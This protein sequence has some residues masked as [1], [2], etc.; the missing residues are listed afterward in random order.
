M[1]LTRLLSLILVLLMFTAT[2]TACVEQGEGNGTTGTEAATVV[3]TGDSVGDGLDDVKYNGATV[4][5]LYWNDATNA[6]F[7]VSE[8][9]ADTINDSVYYRNANVEAHLGIKIAWN[10][11][12]GS[13]SK[14]KAF[15]EYVQNGIEGSTLEVVAAHSMVMGS[16]TASGY[17]QD[18]LDTEY[19]DPDQPCWPKDLIENTTLGG[20]LYFASGDISL[21]TILGMEATFFN[22]ETVDNYNDLYT[23]VE[24]KEWTFDK[25]LEVTKNSY[26]DDGKGEKDAADSFGYVTYGGMINALFVGMGIRIVDKNEDGELVFSKTY[27]SEKTQGLLARINRELY[28]D[29]SRF[30]MGNSDFDGSSAIFLDGRS[31]FYTASVRLAIN[32][33]ANSSIKYGILPNPSYTK[34]DEYHT[35]MANTYTMYGI[36]KGISLDA[37]DKASAFIQAMGSEAYK[38]VTPAVFQVALK[39]Q[40]ADESADSRML[41]IIR[42][43]IVFEIGLIFSDDIADG[44]PSKGLFTC[45]TAKSSDWMSYFGKRVKDETKVFAALNEAFK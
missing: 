2:V 44:M 25:F 32:G 45:V 29:N 12:P 9:S 42:E 10:G 28:D 21:N 20:K 13:K 33:L 35:L 3:T 19:F 30:Y 8:T 40:H 15:K 24:N 36:V 7:E 4:K 27:N 16:L 38:T 17:M 6:E 14:L 43:S 1:K 41:D 37:S 5:V 18:L 23:I 39:L 11:Q 31:K 34:G 26:N 22:K